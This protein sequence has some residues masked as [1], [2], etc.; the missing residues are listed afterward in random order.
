MSQ[1]SKNQ[2]NNNQA[3]PH[4]SRIERLLEENLE[5]SKKIYEAT[6]KMR[7]YINFIRVTN[8]I[9][10]LLIII[11]LVFA[12]I[13]VPPLLQKLI[14]AYQDILGDMSPF[15]ILDQIQNGR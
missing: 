6:S 13:Y 10:L 14:G 2:E 5:Y 7:R 4:G 3:S 15:K 1:D 9:K 8:A 12:L 11:P